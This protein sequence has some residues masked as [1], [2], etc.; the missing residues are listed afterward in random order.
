[1]NNNNI[2][3]ETIVRDIVDIA[4]DVVDTSQETEFLFSNRAKNFKSIADASSRLTLI[5]PTIVSRNI[6]IENA[7]MISKANE[8]QAVSMLQM[9]FSAINISNASNA[10]D[11][12]KQFHTNLKVSDDSITVDD[13]MSTLDSLS[14]IGESGITIRDRELYNKVKN[15]LLNLNY[16]LPESINETS[17]QDYKIINNDYYGRRI[18][19]EGKRQKK[20]NRNSSSISVT[21]LNSPVSQ[22]VNL[23]SN[24]KPMAKPSISIKQ[25]K[26]GSKY[27]DMKN[28]S[29][30]MKNR[31]DV[32]R[33]QLI[34]TDVRKANELVP[35]LMVINFVSKDSKG[36]NNI[37]Q[38]AII[39]VKSKIYPIDSS[40]IMN[41]IVVKNK[42]RNGFLKFIKATTREISFCRDFLFAIDQAKLD[43]L[44]QSNKGSSS[45]LWK[46]L[47]RRSLKS[48]IRRALGSK[49]ND[50]SA[51]STLVI[52]QEEVEYLKKNESIDLTKPAVIRPI[53]E[54]YNLMCFVIVDESMETSSFIYDTGNDIYEEIPFRQLERDSSNNEYKKIINLMTK[55]SR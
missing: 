24:V 41:R 17:L 8:R 18:V 31:S 52:S 29:T 14:D 13:F 2:I 44:S 19:C 48:K 5:F 47:E 25:S 35:T 38:Q 16:T 32:L 51:I 50:A 23:P 36:D 3:H 4:K 42:D 9:L 34:D 20:S 26:Y 12:I 53:M 55:I 10:L 33:N 28:I 46:I 45:K 27:D 54:S 6:S 11:Y 40:D 39:G 1:M 21:K 30:I 37:P 22:T 43:A 15:D 7:S 49:V